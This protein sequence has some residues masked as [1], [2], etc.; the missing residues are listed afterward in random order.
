ML[1][2][3]KACS[4]P[5]VLNRSLMYVG[6]DAAKHKYTARQ[7]TSHQHT[8]AA[9]AAFAQHSMGAFP[10]IGIIRHHRVFHDAYAMARHSRMRR[11]SGTT[12]LNRAN[13]VPT[14]IN[15]MCIPGIRTSHPRGGNCENILIADVI[16]R[17]LYQNVFC[18][19]YA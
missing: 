1:T 18:R 5:P 10:S 9:A 11:Y 2:R 12:V 4:I 8:A 17:K 14:R 19:N 16:T 13:G 15:Q 6:G 3:S 7:H